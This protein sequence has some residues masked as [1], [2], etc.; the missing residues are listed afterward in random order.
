VEITLL[1]QRAYAK[2]RGCAVRAVQ[3][4]IRDGRISTI[5]GMINAEIADREWLAN[6]NPG[7]QH[8]TVSKKVI[9]SSAAVIE[10]G[11][12]ADGTVSTL[13]QA[14]TDREHYEAKLSELK[15]K[16]AAGDLAQVAPLNGWAVG[17]ITEARNILLRIGPE[18]KDKLANETDPHKCEEMVV[19]EVRRALFK[20]SEYRPNAA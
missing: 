18:L 19:S 13:V 20:L 2:H 9:D 6:T 7:K 14:R 17:M 3:K 15:Y 4:A 10:I 11:R 12:P 1:S 16:A 5:E 8:S